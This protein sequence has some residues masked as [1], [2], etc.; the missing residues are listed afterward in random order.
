MKNTSTNNGSGILLM[1]GAGV[2]LLLSGL[3]FVEDH[4]IVALILFIASIISGIAGL[5]QN[6]IAH[7]RR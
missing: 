7:T 1:L 4:S 2:G 3:F 6:Q 5:V